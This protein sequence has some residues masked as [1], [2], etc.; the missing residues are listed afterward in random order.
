M[1]RS[2]PYSSAAGIYDQFQ[3]V[4]G[5]DY[6]AESATVTSHI[7]RLNPD[8]ATLLDCAC[9]TGLHLQHL[10]NN[11]EI[12]GMDLQKPMLDVAREH[13]GNE[14]PLHEG[15]LAT[16]RLGK[17]FDAVVCL[18]SSI[19]YVRPLDRMRQAITNMADHLVPDGVL[20]V[21]PWLTPQSWDDVHGLDTDE[22]E[23]GDRHVV[24]MA[25]SYREGTVSGFDMHYLDGNQE[26]VIYHF[27]RHELELYT[28]EQY[29]EAFADANLAVEHDAHGL[30]GR[31][32]IIGQMN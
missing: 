3:V 18:F 32:L 22:F 23:D 21:E 8:A 27:E 9:G 31:G 16:M 13:L 25:N 28:I 7:K 14:V 1:A 5:K 15:D 4:R 20:I 30:I 26:R 29:M 19:G 2:T 6:A 11:F 24:R 12:A 17:R 10:G